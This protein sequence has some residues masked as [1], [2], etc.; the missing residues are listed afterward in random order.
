MVPL[1]RGLRRVELLG[2][3]DV[4]VVTVVGG[5]DI[6]WVLGVPELLVQDV[7]VRT[8][9]LGRTREARA[10]QTELGNLSLRRVR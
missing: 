9:W 6:R 4:R 5:A 1:G 10:Y 7:V 8:S 2:E 3:L